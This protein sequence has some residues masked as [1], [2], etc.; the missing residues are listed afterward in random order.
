MKKILLALAIALMAVGVNAQELVN[1]NRGGGRAPSPEIAEGKVTFRLSANYA[2]VV[3]LNG[4]WPGGRNIAMNKGEGGLWSVTVDLPEPEIYTYS[5]SVDGVSVNDP[6]NVLVQRDGTRYLPI[7][8]VPGPRSENYVE[9]TRHGTVSH[10]W[11]DSQILG[12][13]RRRN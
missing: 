11:Y 9:A 8:T 3:T 4:S 5:F 13:S 2:T 1:V 7:L 12:F 6:Q 10:P